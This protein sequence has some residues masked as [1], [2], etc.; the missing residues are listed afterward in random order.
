MVNA[1][2]NV[3]YM[4]KQI[5]SSDTAVT[6]VPIG[7]WDE[8]NDRPIGYVDVPFTAWV[9]DEQHDE[10]YQVAV[11]FIEAKS[12]EMPIHSRSKSG[13]YLGSGNILCLKQVNS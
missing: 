6:K 5:T 10:E 7:K 3:Y 11:G 8:V 1:A 4:P 9:V 2:N 12:T 13:W